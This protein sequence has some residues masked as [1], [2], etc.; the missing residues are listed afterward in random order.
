[1]AWSGST[2]AAKVTRLYS[3]SLW[4]NLPRTSGVLIAA[5]HGISS[6]STVLDGEVWSSFQGVC[7]VVSLTKFCSKKSWKQRPLFL[8]TISKQEWR[9]KSVAIGKPFS[10]LISETMFWRS[11][12]RSFLW[13]ISSYCHPGFVVTGGDV[14]AEVNRSSLMVAQ[15]PVIRQYCIK[16]RQ[17]G[18][19]RTHKHSPTGLRIFEAS[20]LL[21]Y[22][23]HASLP[24]RWLSCRMSSYTARPKCLNMFV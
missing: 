18:A 21:K 14:R 11:R 23:N 13:E 10:G 24:R 4:Q 20:Q 6:G 15:L 17:R 7:F 22:P 2:R 19:T 9:W 1:M 12:I 16:P 5:P 3:V 8:G